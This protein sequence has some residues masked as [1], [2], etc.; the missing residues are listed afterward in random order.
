MSEFPQNLD[1][2]LDLPRVDDNIAEI[3]ATAINALRDAVFAIESNIGVGAAGGTSSIAARLGQSLDANGNLSPS[4]LINLLNNPAFQITNQQVSTSAAIAESKLNLAYHTSYLHNLICNNAIDV[5]TAIQ[6]VQNSGFKL[7][8]HIAGTNYNHFMSAILVSASTSGYFLNNLGL[9]RNNSNLYQLFSDINCDLIHHENAYGNLPEVNPPSSGFA[10]WASGVEINS[11]V[12]RSIPE[13]VNDV[14]SL[15]QFIDQANIFLIGTRIQN[16][17]QNGI[18]RVSRSYILTSGTAADG[19][20]YNGKLILPLTPATTYLAN[21]GTM[22]IDSIMF[23]DDVVKID[24]SAN[25][26]L[27]VSQ[28]SQVIIG[29]E[30][31]I[32]YGSVSGTFIIKETAFDGYGGTYAYVRLDRKNLAETA[33]DGA[34]VQINRSLVNKN[35]YG[36]LALAQVPIPNSINPLPLPSLIC[37]QPSGASVLGIN[38][39]ADSFD[40]SHYCL[41][42]SL[43]P[44]GNPASQTINL[45]PI[46]VTGNAGAKPGQYRLDSIVAST[47]AAF[48][49]PGYNYRFTAFQYEG[50][51]GIMIAD[52]YGG[53][54]FSINSSDNNENPLLNNVVDNDGYIDPLGFG[55]S[56]ANLAS[57]QFTSLFPTI[58]AAIMN[59]TKIFVPLNNNTYY[60]NGSE[61]S[62]VGLEPE[63]TLDGLGSSYWPATITQVNTTSHVQVT[64]TIDLN[65]SG[66]GLS[67]GKTIV[68]QSSG[69]GGTENDFGRFII[70]SVNFT[71]GCDND[72]YT[73]EITVYD[74]VHAAGTSPY[75]T[76]PVGT[77]VNIYFTQDSIGFNTQNVFDS[78][79]NINNP[80]YNP[81]SYKRHFEVLIDDDGYTFSHERGRMNATASSFYLDT[82]NTLLISGS[83][84]VTT[85]IYKISPKLRGYTYSNVTKISLQIISYNQTSGI[86]I[87]QL[88]NTWNGVSNLGPITTGKQGEIVRFYDETNIDYIDFVFTGTTALT[89][90]STQTIDI[91]LFPSLS[92]DDELMLLGTCQVNDI[93]NS[94]SITY[95]VDQ[96]EF[97]NTSEEQFTTSALDYI[98]APTRLLNE[99]GIIR[100]FDIVGIPTVISPYSNLL[101]ISGGEAI[102]NGKIIQINNQEISIPIVQEIA[103]GNLIPQI[104][105]FICVNDKS[106]IELVASTDFDPNGVYASSYSTPIVLDN[107]RIFYVQNPNAATHVSYPIRATYLADLVQNQKDLALIGIITTTIS[108]QSPWVITTI[109]PTVASSC[110]ARRYIGGGYSGLISPFVLATN[111]SFRS[112]TSLNNWLNQLTSF[113][114]STTNSNTLG[115]TVIVKGNFNILTPETLN[116]SDVI[117]FQGDGGTFTIQTLT[118]FNLQNNVLFKNVRFNYMYTDGY[119]TSSQTLCNLANPNGFAALQCNVSSNTNIGF[120]ECIFNSPYQYRYAFIGFNFASSNCY[121]QN[122]RI[123][124]NR[125]ETSYAADDQLAVIAFVAPAI[126]PTSSTGARLNNC[127]IENNYCNKNQLI[128]IASP[129]DT[130]T[131]TINDL[132]AATNVSIA[133]NTCGAINVMVKQDMALYNTPNITF[134]LDKPSDGV[135]IARNTCRYIYSGFADGNFIDSSGD[136]AITDVA[137]GFI[138]GNLSIYN[139]NVSWIHVA[140]RV[141]FSNAN[142]PTL[143]VKE[144]KCTAY[145]PHYLLPY[146]QN[147][148]SLF[149]GFTIANSANIGVFVNKVVGY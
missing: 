2:D 61:I 101:A 134:N 149:P 20:N 10:H 77:A 69:I 58:P 81:N 29:D 37:G 16:L 4:V 73:T 50:N 65:L 117:T 88:C 141:L 27:F 71:C 70:S 36:V 32:N 110:D 109:S 112:F 74:A 103:N 144:N 118:G 126:A 49:A 52:P 62:V 116:Y 92:L 56:N 76:S 13:S 130:I 83:N 128:V 66:S 41:Y 46:D 143:I 146:F 28:F 42:L 45:P 148:S 59:A 108:N 135:S 18:S 31:S 87:G 106:E 79:P 60:V 8:P 47:N 121:L 142:T 114:S 139:N 107:T 124:Y 125:F 5:Q 75:P 113:I 98:S 15:A 63:Q 93:P 48:R 38:F 132:I 26:T 54:S 104:T 147:S 89:L 99:N 102:V 12:F 23:G 100:G 94:N 119:N 22:P 43:Y 21:G 122:V 111:G 30:I 25:P 55:L 40:S 3:G 51:F 7:E 44:N 68:V 115:K 33:V 96:R 39:N 123:V 120:E 17:Y 131:T 57:P 86:Y 80:S 133:R 136:Q 34:M 72:G 140:Y 82:G 85:N 129:L 91:Q 6:Y 138:V 127:V 145:Y 35:K 90:P 105:W 64:Y 78:A 84:I 11:S 1:S 14:Q 9:Q 19:Y 95:L 53:A 137:N 24:G 97:G 67:A